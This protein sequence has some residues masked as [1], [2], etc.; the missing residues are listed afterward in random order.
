ML[1]HVL[2][3]LPEEAC[4]LLGGRQGKSEVVYDVTNELRS[5]TRFRMEPHQQ[6]H[7]ML[8][9]ENSGLDLL[10]IYHSHPAGPDHPS[11]TDIEEFRYPGIVY[12][13]WSPLNADWECRGFELYE[14][15]YIETPLSVVED[16]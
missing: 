1:D 6:I 16:E 3:C 4:G 5:R 10:A 11:R 2:R 7:A 9:I 14:E 12:L 8:S 15:G 13:I